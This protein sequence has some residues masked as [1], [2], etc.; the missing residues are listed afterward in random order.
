[1]YILP[2]AYS[3]KQHVSL[4]LRYLTEMHLHTTYLP[5]SQLPFFLAEPLSLPANLR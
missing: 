5:I 4:S 2:P 3:D 1:M